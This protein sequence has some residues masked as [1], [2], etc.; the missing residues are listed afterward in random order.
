[1]L[2]KNFLEQR[3]WQRSLVNKIQQRKLLGAGKLEIMKTIKIAWS[4]E[5]G[6]KS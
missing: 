4:R 6:N 2:K 5:V 1:M 3:N